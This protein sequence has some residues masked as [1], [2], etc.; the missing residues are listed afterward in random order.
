MT[1]LVPRRTLTGR[2]SRARVIDCITGGGP[3]V[4]VRGASARWADDL[5][6]DLRALGRDVQVITGQG[7]P[8]LPAL[9]T[10]LQDLRPLRPETV[11]AVG[12]GSV[13]DLGKALA[14]LLPATGDPLDHLEVVGQGL[15]LT[16]DPLFYIAVP[17]T[18]G[19]GA[20][21]TKN[22]VIDVPE[23]R[24]KV[25]LR[26]ARMLPDVAVLDGALTDGTPWPVTL[27]CGMDAL[28]Q[29]IEPYLSSR[30]MPETDA[31]CAAAIGPT[32]HAL[33]TLSR[34]EDA[35]ARDTLLAAAHLSGIALANAGLG[36]VHGLAGVIGGQ[37]G[38]PHGAIC[39][40]LLP[41]VLRANRH[42]CQQAGLS[43]ARFDDV[44]R[45]VTAVCTGDTAADALTG[46]L[47]GAP[48]AQMG[49]MEDATVADMAASSS[50]MKG[51]PVSLPPAI[52][53]EILA[54]GR[55]L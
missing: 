14:A 5:V 10:H 13:I 34:G 15:P 54:E 44:D 42:A 50:S 1:L 26:D 25:S 31:I 28:T 52:L 17:T 21:A 43:V 16:T 20:E 46:F 19:T 7:E 29:L 51:N 36:A 27:A 40:R 49:A 6:A 41:A 45:W 11:V 4:V 47:S 23:H 39:A 38:A 55:A 48:L 22:A 9:V 33:M 8:S 12:G 24:R 30:A 35:Q 37:T 53:Q 32:M 2:G 18:S 3:A